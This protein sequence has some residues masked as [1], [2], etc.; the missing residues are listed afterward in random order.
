MGWLCLVA[1]VILS[2]I[3]FLIL[4]YVGPARLSEMQKLDRIAAYKTN[5][6]IAYVQAFAPA[7]HF[8]KKKLQADE[9]Y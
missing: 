2:C 3:A 8:I 9:Y 5:S 6:K 4:K 1:F 7:A